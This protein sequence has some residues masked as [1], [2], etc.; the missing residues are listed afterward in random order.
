MASPPPPTITCLT[1]GRLRILVNGTYCK[2]RL[3]FFGIGFFR[4]FS[5]LC[6]CQRIVCMVI[7]NSYSRIFSDVSA[8]VFSFLCMNRPSSIWSQL[9]NCP[10][11]CLIN[12][13]REP[14]PPPPSQNDKKGWKWVKYQIMSRFPV[15]SSRCLYLTPHQSSNGGVGD[16]N[17][18][19]ILSNIILDLP[20]VSVNIFVAAVRVWCVVGGVSTNAYVFFLYFRVSPRFLAAAA[21]LFAFRFCVLFAGCVRIRP[22][23]RKRCVRKALR[24]WNFEFFEFGKSS[25]GFV[26]LLEQALNV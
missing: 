17:I 21:C 12:E 10:W 9:R 22:R 7:V 4:L 25:G 2:G 20:I 6:R 11:S 3:L 8:T 24:F 16:Q 18:N 15:C 23:V 19:L 13:R 14:P 26:L 5:C 1:S